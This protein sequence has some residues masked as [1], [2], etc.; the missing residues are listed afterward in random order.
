[1]RESSEK[2]QPLYPDAK[3]IATG[4]SLVVSLA[5]DR[6]ITFQTGFEG[7][8]PDPVVNARLD[9]L[10]RFADRLKAKAEIPEIEA[11]LRKQRETLAQFREDRA[12]VGAEHEHQQALRQ[13]ELDERVKHREQARKE[14][15][16]GIDAS[17]LSMQQA[18]QKIWNAGA[19]EYARSG[20]L[21]A[22]MPRGAAAS[23]LEKVD[24][25]IAEASV[26]REKALADFDNDYQIGLDTAQGEIDKA[27]AEREAAERSLN[28]SIERY[29]TA[30]ASQEAHL[31][32]CQELAGG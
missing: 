21:T 11:D 28:I 31:A 26:H 9:R 3:N 13:V 19:E 29:E 20:R 18:K 2:V 22:Y 12:R 25:A 6:Q 15:Q 1:M 8:E 4:V 32:K 14:F 16:A 10:C 17:I 24:K 23:N 27:N 7:D 30:I 5:S